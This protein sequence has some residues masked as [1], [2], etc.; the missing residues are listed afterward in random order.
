MHSRWVGK[1]K[2]VQRQQEIFLTLRDHTGVKQA[3]SEG[4]GSRSHGKPLV[5]GSLGAGNRIKPSE[6]KSS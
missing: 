5:L 3:A 4:L 1:Q 6:S 2:I